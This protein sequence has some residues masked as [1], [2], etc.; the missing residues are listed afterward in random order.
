MTSFPHQ[1]LHKWIGW[2]GT[3]TALADYGLFAMGYLSDVWFFSLGA[4]ASSLLVIA[5]LKDKT[6]YAAFLQAAFIFLN[7]IGAMRLIWSH[8][9]IL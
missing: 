9:P 1:P 2:T 3:L 4:L 8:W 6:Y 5:L 7:L